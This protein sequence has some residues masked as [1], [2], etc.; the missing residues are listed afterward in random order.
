MCVKDPFCRASPPRL[1]TPLSRR[2]GAR[3]TSR[4][5]PVPLLLCAGALLSQPVLRAARG[6]ARTQKK[7]HK[8]PAGQVAAGPAGVVRLFCQLI[9]PAQPCRTASA[10]PPPP[11]RRTAPQSP[12]IR[13]P[14]TCLSRVVCHVRWEP[15]LLVV[16]PG[17]ISGY[18]VGFA[19]LP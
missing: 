17:G 1:T 15:V 11:H 13:A 10:A 18:G 7:R 19:S 4:R 3:R 16:R 6:A 9:P 12:L 2:P 5:P 8:A 14:T